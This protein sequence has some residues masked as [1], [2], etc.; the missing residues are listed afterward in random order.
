MRTICWVGLAV[1][2][3][4]SPAF[5]QSESTGASA[6]LPALSHFDSNVVNGDVDPCVDFYKFAYS[7]WLAANPIPADQAYWDTSSNLQL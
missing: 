6:A 2:V 7:K 4:I 5:G 1:I 3:V